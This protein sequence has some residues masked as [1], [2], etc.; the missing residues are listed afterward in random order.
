M[1]LLVENMG[2]WKVG[3]RKTGSRS[4]SYASV[5][6]K[7]E[8]LVEKTVWFQIRERVVQDREEK[9]RRY[10]FGKFSEGPFSV[11]EN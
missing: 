7:N 8:G 2:S 5:V 6:R 3:S 10:L 9:L 11:S 1:N 4:M